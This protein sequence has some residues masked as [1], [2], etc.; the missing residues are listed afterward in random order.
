M[1]FVCPLVGPPNGPNFVSIG[2]VRKI[3][4]VGPLVG[5][6]EQEAQNHK[7]EA[8]TDKERDNAISKAVIDM[9]EYL[10]DRGVG[11]Y[12]ALEH[13]ASDLDREYDY[14][15]WTIREPAIQET[16]DIVWSEWNETCTNKL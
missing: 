3:F 12:R 16:V 11:K 9:V 10:H 14:L 8:M 7:G 2:G 15:P 4:F 1:F 13:I 6:H 5:H